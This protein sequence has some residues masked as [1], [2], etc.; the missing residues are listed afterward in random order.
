MPVFKK[1]LFSKNIHNDLTGNFAKT[2]KYLKKYKTSLVSEKDLITLHTTMWAKIT[3][4]VGENT[5]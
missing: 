4:N 3:V 5:E 2:K 1:K